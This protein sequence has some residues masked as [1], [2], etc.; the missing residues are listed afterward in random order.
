MNSAFARLGKKDKVESTQKRLR[1]KLNKRITREEVKALKEENSDLFD[2]LLSKQKKIQSKDLHIKLDGRL[3]LQNLFD[4]LYPEHEALCLTC[5]K[6]VGWAGTCYKEFCSKKCVNASNVI[7]ERR[8]AT[9][10][11][12]F[13]ME[14][15]LHPKIKKKKIEKFLKRYGVENP[16]QAEEIKLKKAETCRKN[17]GVDHWEKLKQGHFSINN[18]MKTKKGR[19][20]YHKAMLKLYGVDIPLKSKEI[21]K[22]MIDTH[23]KRYGGNG[24]G[25]AS[26]FKRKEVVDAFGKLHKVQGHEPKAIEWLGNRESV[27][28][29]ISSYK[30]VPNINYTDSKGRGR[31]YKPDLVVKKMNGSKHIIEVKGSWPLKCSFDDIVAKAKA[32]SAYAKEQGCHYWFFYYRDDGNLVKLKN[33][34]SKK[35]FSRLLVKH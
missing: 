18:P 32:A 13:G 34:S 29:I 25:I 4:Y 17:H 11:E 3:K 16:S 19:R 9:C 35:I 27:V 31:V 23:M 28:K 14:P 30:K 2:K 15:N 8:K 6:E 12:R 5:G 10:I 33:P 20:A 22:K 26:R 7:V 24:G 21:S 1:K